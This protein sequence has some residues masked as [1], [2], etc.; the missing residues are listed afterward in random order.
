MQIVYKKILEVAVWH[1]YYLRSEI[2]IDGPIVDAINANSAGTETPFETIVKIIDNDLVADTL[3]DELK[4]IVWATENASNNLVVYRWPESYNI[5]NDLDFI[6][7]PEC[8]AL[9]Q[10]QKI[11][12]RKT[13]IG[14]TLLVKVAPS[15]V[16]PQK[17]QTFTFLA[18]DAKFS[19]FILSRNPFF[20]NFTNIRLTGT[21]NG[22]YHFHNRAR[23]PLLT[24]RFY[25]TNPHPIVADGTTGFQLGDILEN[26]TLL[27]EI[28][29]P[30]AFDLSVDLNIGENTTRY[31]TAEDRL[32][33][34]FPN[35]QYADTNNT[36]PGEI[37]HFSLFDIDGNTVEL[38]MIPGTGLPQSRYQAPFNSSQPLF[39][40]INLSEIPPGKYTLQI[41][42]VGGNETQE[43]YLLDP[44]IRADAFGMIELWANDATAGFIDYQGNESILAPKDFQ[45]RFKNRSTVWQYFDKANAELTDP[46]NEVILPLTQ[47]LSNFKLSTDVLPDPGVSIVYP[48][49]DNNGTIRKIYSKTYLNQ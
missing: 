35:F 15:I 37:V 16:D 20:S 40:S 25:L 22:L 31:A 2:L 3:L 13:P 29:E 11:V 27:Y 14:F 8:S 6:P 44:L 36:N 9:M 46:N 24:N 38:G 12:F 5:L 21:N 1:D 19:F 26:N 18:Q 7:T 41:S 47:Q 32:P 34:Q 33:W 39:H 10:N 23:V 30:D 48:E 45:I 17:F 49:R 42:R 28:I 4:A 43:F